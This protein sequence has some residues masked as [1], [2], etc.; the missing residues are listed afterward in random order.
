MIN[1]DINSRRCK[2]FFCNRMRG[3]YCC[4]D[5]EHKRNCKNKCLNSQS[6]CKSARSD[7]EIRGMMADKGN[8]IYLRNYCV[9]SGGSDKSDN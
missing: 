1:P 3:A 9:V 5:C 4:N 7:T 6:K 8:E 2:L